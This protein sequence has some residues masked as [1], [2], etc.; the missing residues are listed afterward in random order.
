MGC[1]A[2]QHAALGLSASRLS[3]AEWSIFQGYKR[4][5]GS[6]T[7]EGQ[8]GRNLACCG[9]VSDS[10]QF[11]PMPLVNNKVGDDCT[12]SSDKALADGKALVDSLIKV[13]YTGF[14]GYF[15]CKKSMQRPNFSTINQVFP[16][17][18]ILLRNHVWIWDECHLW[19]IR[20]MFDIKTLLQ[21]ELYCIVMGICI[22]KFILNPSCPLHYAQTWR[23]VKNIKKSSLPLQLKEHSLW[24]E[25]LGPLHLCGSSI[26]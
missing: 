7:S 14:Y 12:A 11:I 19:E 6:W 10:V 25:T 5:R 8:W 15:Y 2:L 9:R 16:K 1:S 22:K 24:K 21:R 13:R 17:P 23:Y 26:S 4:S 18:L 20:E 3:G